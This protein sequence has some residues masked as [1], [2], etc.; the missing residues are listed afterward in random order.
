MGQTFVRHAGH[1]EEDEGIPWQG[2]LTSQGH[3]GDVKRYRTSH[4]RGVVR[5]VNDV[6]VFFSVKPL[7]YATLTNDRES[8]SHYAPRTLNIPTKFEVDIIVHYQTHLWHFCCR[9]LRDH[10]TLTCDLW[11]LVFIKCEGHMIN[12]ST[13]FENPVNNRSWVMKTFKMTWLRHTG[14]GPYTE[15]T[16]VIKLWMLEWQRTF[17]ENIETLENFYVRK[18][19]KMPCFCHHLHLGDTLSSADYYDFFLSYFTE[20]VLQNVEKFVWSTS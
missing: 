19:A 1:S 11:Y 12:P 14:V 4:K 5:R 8:I 18:S 7:E 17:C 13:K 6:D 2:D 9:T 10:V 16:S 3:E 15:Q 20:I